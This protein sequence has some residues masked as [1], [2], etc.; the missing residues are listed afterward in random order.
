MK[1]TRLSL[2]LKPGEG[3]KIGENVLMHRDAYGL[4][5]MLIHIEAPKDVIISRVGKVPPRTK[6]SDQMD[7]EDG[8]AEGN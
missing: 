3:V 4:G 1:T 6:K 5:Q 2:K 7:F 8:D